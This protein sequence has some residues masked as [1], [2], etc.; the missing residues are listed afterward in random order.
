MGDDFSVCFAFIFDSEMNG[1]RQ[2]IR[3]GLTD[4]PQVGCGLM[5]QIIDEGKPAMADSYPVLNVL[6]LAGLLI[7]LNAASTILS[8]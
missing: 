8:Q 2:L 6:R 3:I 1:S 7:S 4:D 5:S